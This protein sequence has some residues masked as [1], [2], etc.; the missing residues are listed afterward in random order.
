VHLSVKFVEHEWECSDLL[1]NY[2]PLFPAEDCTG[3]GRGVMFTYSESQ[4]SSS[5]NL[6]HHAHHIGRLIH[7]ARFELHSGP[8]QSLQSRRHHRRAASGTRYLFERG[9]KASLLAAGATAP[10]KLQVEFKKRPINAAH[11]IV[12]VIGNN[13][14]IE[15][16]AISGRGGCA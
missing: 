12:N 3:A 10:Y 16:V 2:K 9:R 15:G 13:A 5:R 14:L 11:A 6:F 7:L 8:P 1:K 4:K